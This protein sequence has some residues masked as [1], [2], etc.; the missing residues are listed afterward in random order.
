MT[1]TMDQGRARAAA[2]RPLG[3]LVSRTAALLAAACTADPPASSAGPRPTRVVNTRAQATRER[4]SQARSADPA[5]ASGALAATEPGRNDMRW[6]TAAG[7]ILASLALVATASG[8]AASDEPELEGTAAIVW[9]PCP[10]TPAVQSPGP[11]S[12]PGLCALVARLDSHRPSDPPW[13]IPGIMRFL[14]PSP[15]IT[16]SPT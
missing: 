5:R 15:S 3:A 16:L 12:P 4:M 7:A 6:M 11:D 8:A 10:D 1:S 14:S 9:Q 13:R 2:C